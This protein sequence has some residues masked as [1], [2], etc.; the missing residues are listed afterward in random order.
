MLRHCGFV[1]CDTQVR[2]IT[3]LDMA[4]HNIWANSLPPSTWH[5]PFTH[6]HLASYCMRL[7]RNRIL[8]FVQSQP[9]VCW[10]LRTCI[11]ELLI[12]G[13]MSHKHGDK[14]IVGQLFTF[15]KSLLFWYYIK[16]FWKILVLVWHLI[17]TGGAVVGP[18]LLQKTISSECEN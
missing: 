7:N 9:I 5:L 11:L 16:C 17:R 2:Q 15:I 13:L 3:T 18:G 6:D 4:A 14:T 10:M 1:F 12:I 8:D